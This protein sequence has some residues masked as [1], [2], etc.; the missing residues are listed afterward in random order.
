MNIPDQLMLGGAAMA[1]ASIVLV[2]M[3]IFLGNREEKKHQKRK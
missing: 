1:L 3:A 2:A